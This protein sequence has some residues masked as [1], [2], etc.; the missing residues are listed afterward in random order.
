MQTTQVALQPVSEVFL[1][2]TLAGHVF[3]CATACFQGVFGRK[4]MQATHVVALQPA[5][6]VFWLQAHA[7]QLIGY[8]TACLQSVLG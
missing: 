6:K 5:P 3:G 4:N 7:G 1:A 8:A 2:E